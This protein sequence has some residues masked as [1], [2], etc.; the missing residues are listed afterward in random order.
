[1]LTHIAAAFAFLVAASPS[2]PTVYLN[3]VV[4]DGVAFAGQK[5]EGATVS[6]DQKGNVY[7]V[8][9][10]YVVDVV[11]EKSEPLTKK[12]FLLAEQQN[13]GAA[14]FDIDVFINGVFLRTLKSSD[15]QVLIE[16]DD[17][18]AKGK[19]TVYL[20]ARK[21]TSEVRK[22]V[23]PKDVFH[24]QIGEGHRAEKNLMLDSIIV[25]YTRTAAETGS[26]DQS[27]TLTAR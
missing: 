10:N 21:I 18:L 20:A 13:V 1:M 23:D 3:G 7:I 2:T 11:K 25:D 17:K 4:L 22:S 14:Q 24:V 8:A 16:L 27:Y 5:V 15:E 19:N 6:F 26:M 12:Y 9:K